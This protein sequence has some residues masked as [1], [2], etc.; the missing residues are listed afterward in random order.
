M[1]ESDQQE[2][3]VR[4]RLSRFQISVSGLTVIVVCCALVLWSYRKVREL[5]HPS[6]AQARLLRSGD[7]DQREEAARFFLISD[8]GESTIASAA[9]I[10][11]LK[12]ENVRVQCEAVRALGVVAKQLMGPSASPGGA[13]PAIEALSKVLLDRQAETRAPDSS[14]LSRAVGEA[15][16]NSIGKR[17]RIRPDGPAPWP[18]ES[19]NFDLAQVMDDPTWMAAR[20]L[21]EAAPNSDC[22]EIALVALT[23]A[24]RTESDER[25]LRV[26]TRSLARFGPAAARVL[27]DMTLALRKAA[28]ARGTS[29]VWLWTSAE[30]VVR[31]APGTSEAD[32]AIKALT[33]CL[34][35]R[36]DNERRVLAIQSLVRM[37]PAAHAAAPALIDIMKGGYTSPEAYIGRLWVPEALGKI[38]P[39]TPS[40]ATAILAL[41]DALDVDDTDLRLGA[42]QA[43]SRFGAAAKSAIPRIE[44]LRGVIAFRGL[45][46]RVIDAIN[47][48]R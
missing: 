25:R 28:A 35:V 2:P 43:L 4:R 8:P 42:L 17:A 21:G 11:A 33:D 24:L 32:E 12:D 30:T 39:G 5:G 48:G 46:A 13:R 45:G 44:A 36:D 19:E 34:R 6:I 27:P 38:A 16:G 9:L 31:I 20:A 40:A 1:G 47:R 22:A 10:D 18:D 23:I 14:N 37:G 26:I 7:R 41:T 29:D 3:G 15:R